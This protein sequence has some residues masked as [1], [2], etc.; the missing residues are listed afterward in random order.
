MSQQNP[1]QECNCDNKVK[2]LEKQVAELKGTVSYLSE[3]LL[4]LA[5]EVATLRKAVR[6]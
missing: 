1:K 3:M 6:K 4:T 5:K 2:S